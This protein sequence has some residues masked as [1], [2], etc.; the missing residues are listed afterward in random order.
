M[1]RTAKPGE[2]SIGGYFRK[3]FSEKPDLLFTKSNNELRARWLADHPGYSEVPHRILQ[4]LSNV[5]SVLRQ[6]NRKKRGRPPKSSLGT[7]GAP[8]FSGSA[9]TPAPRPAPKGMEGLEESIDDCL[10]M[11]KH[12]DREG[13]AHIIKHLRAARNEVVWKMG[14]S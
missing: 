11:A 4:N 5:K 12:M 7:T 13:L 1:A 2:E 10:S 9:P 6:K 8:M 3:V 14:Q